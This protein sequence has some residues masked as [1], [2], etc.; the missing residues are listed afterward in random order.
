[1]RDYSLTALLDF[2]DFLNN[3]EADNKAIGWNR[4]TACKKVISLLPPDFQKDV[5]KID[6]KEAMRV[7]LR[8]Y[9][10]A[11]V[12]TVR[13]YRRR[14][15]EALKAFTGEAKIDA[16]PGVSTE[17]VGQ[18]FME[19]SFKQSVTLPYTVWIALRSD[20]IAELTLPYDVTV[21]EAAFLSK[22]LDLAA[23]ASLMRQQ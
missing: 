17:E 3:E 21:E 20:F 14:M 19:P 15:K 8:H 23:E 22:H 1:M 16:E 7:Y 10:N 13:E 6:P 4:K 9:P 2:C 5:R 11:S 12:N 18:N